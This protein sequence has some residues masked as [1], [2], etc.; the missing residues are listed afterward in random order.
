MSSWAQGWQENTIY[1]GIVAK[2]SDVGSQGEGQWKNKNVNFID[3]QHI[4]PKL[5][6]HVEKK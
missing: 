5:F 6:G 1:F 3:F 2:E 4:F